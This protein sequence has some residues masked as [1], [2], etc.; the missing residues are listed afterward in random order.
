MDAEPASYRDGVEPAALEERVQP[1]GEV[2]RPAARA[3]GVRQPAERERRVLAR[4][5][6][7]GRVA[8]PP[9][10]D[11]RTDPSMRQEASAPPVRAGNGGPSVGRCPAGRPTPPARG[12]RARRETLVEAAGPP[13]KCDDLLARDL[14]RRH[15]R[16][17]RDAGRRGRPGSTRDR[18]RS[19]RARGSGP[20]SSSPRESGR[21]PRRAVP[22]GRARTRG[23][24]RSGRCRGT[25]EPR[26]EHVDRL[27]PTPRSARTRAPPPSVPTETART[28][29]RASR[30]PRGSSSL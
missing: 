4:R 18:R 17:V 23:C 29:R 1:R 6:D 19:A 24:T 10:L 26:L 5:D 20:P 3:A 27:V 12:M 7:V 21:A 15:L 16:R 11:E 30:R 14:E 8:E 9:D 28:R 13:A 22:P 2:L 25:G